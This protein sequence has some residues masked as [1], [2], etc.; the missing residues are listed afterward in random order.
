LAAGFLLEDGKDSTSQS[1]GET[2]MT[3]MMVAR[4]DHWGWEVEE[5]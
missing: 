3:K 5:S 4:M 2:R 1:Y